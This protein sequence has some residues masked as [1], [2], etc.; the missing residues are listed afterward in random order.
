M[1]IW[2]YTLRRGVIGLKRIISLIISLTICLMCLPG[3]GFAARANDGDASRYIVLM[4][5]PA[6]YSEDSVI[7][8]GADED[9]KTQLRDAIIDM[10]A[11]IKKQIAP[12]VSLFGLSDTDFFEGEYSFTDVANGFTVTCDAAMAEAIAQIDGVKAVFPDA[13]V[14]TIPNVDI[15]A[16]SQDVVQTSDA[17]LADGLSASNSASDINVKYAYENNL[18]GKGRAIAVLDSTLSFN[19]SYFTM[20]EDT[21]LKYTAQSIASAITNAGLDDK[22]KQ[23]TYKNSKFPFVYNFVQDSSSLYSFSSNTAQAVHGTHVSGI[24]AGYNFKLSQTNIFRGVAPDAQVLFGGVADSSTGQINISA[25]TSAIDVMVKI[26]V[27]AINCSFGMD[28]A[29]ENNITEKKKL[30][31]EAVRNAENAGVT[32]NFSAGNN[33]RYGIT[34]PSI[35]EYSSADNSLYP[36][37]TRVGSVQTKYAQMLRLFNNADNTVIYPASPMMANTTTVSAE[38][39]D[40]KNGTQEDFASV[41]INDKIAV[42]QRPDDFVSEDTITYYNR[43]QKKNAKGL[44]IIN[45][46][47]QLDGGTFGN[48][49]D[50]NTERTCMLF[51]MTKSVGER[52]LADINDGGL[53]IKISNQGIMAENS[54]TSEASLFSAYGISDS[55]EMTV[56]FAA[57]GGNIFSSFGADSYGF[58]SGTSQAAPQITGACALMYPYVEEAFPAYTGKEKVKLVKN[59]FASTAKNVY[60]YDGDDDDTNNPLSSVRKVGSGIIQLDAA[61]KSKVRL[62]D[63]ECDKSYVSIGDQTGNVFAVEFNVENLSTTDDVVFDTAEVKV[64]TDKVTDYGVKGKAYSGVQALNAAISGFDEPLKVQK[65]E[66]KK[67]S[68]TVTLD[69]EQ[70][71]ALMAD[72]VNGFYVDGKITLSAIDGSHVD[73]GIAFMGFYGDWNAQPII[74]SEN[75][76]EHI[77]FNVL[78]DGQVPIYAVATKEDGVYKVPLP[79]TPDKHIAQSNLH[80]MTNLK[81]NAAITFEQGEGSETITVFLPKNTGVNIIKYRELA[82]IT[83]VLKPT[84]TLTLPKENKNGITLT[85]KYSFETFKRADLPTLSN[86]KVDSGIF[87][88]EFDAYNPSALLVK[89]TDEDDKTKLAAYKLSSTATKASVNVSDYGK[90]SFYLY[91]GALNVV[92]LEHNISVTPD[93]K[94]NAVLTNTSINTAGGR[95]LIAIYDESGRMT[96]I[97]ELTNESIMPYKSKEVPIT[98]ADYKDKHYKI[99]WISAERIQPNCKMYDSAK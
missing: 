40:C 58:M 60:E 77:A 45:N 98:I 6:V 52:L 72:M 78:Y 25:I 83:A 99:F 44:I 30:E 16:A 79:T 48:L 20:P 91:D 51:T 18:T 54:L 67:V 5:A 37:A 10:Q 50:D 88:T 4:D 63:T 94:G 14:A 53:E 21:E 35:I 81:R 2:Y 31:I 27:D 95:C 84:I 66:T 76:N 85:E 82:N 9:Y 15:K 56:D 68:L 11:E 28:G 75:I 65:G 74:D 26:G 39:V 41:D 47:N 64:S 22:Y 69:E 97:K 38:V 12:P 8:Y 23:G 93:E 13:A 29:S 87:S 86:S 70:T 19:H 17:T 32:I 49:N 71:A 42:M 61:M 7:P 34:D 3:N 24:A 33:D 43:A 92:E 57:P 36:Y 96:D 1:R 46:I 55:I 89:Y 90:A 80:I 73:V 59:L 62:L